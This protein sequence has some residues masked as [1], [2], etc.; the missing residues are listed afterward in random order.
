MLILLRFL[1]L[2][3]DEKPN[4]INEGIVKSDRL[5]A[6]SHSLGFDRLRRDDDCGLVFDNC[7]RIID[8]VRSEIPLHALWICPY[9][10]VPKYFYESAGW[11]PVSRR[12]LPNSFDE[13]VL[14]ERLLH[15]P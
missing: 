4:D 8:L 15:H 9:G 11:S 10:L 5:L 7:D 13:L 6:A 3:K 1:L 14:H 12:Q 2:G